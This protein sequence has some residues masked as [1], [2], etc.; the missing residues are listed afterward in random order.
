M[1]PATIILCMAIMLFVA[2]VIGGLA[3]LAV[4]LII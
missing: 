1:N 4:F 2:A 3:G